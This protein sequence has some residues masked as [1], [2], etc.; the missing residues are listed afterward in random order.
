VQTV[1]TKFVPRLLTAEWKQH[2]LP[3][4]SNLLKCAETHE[5]FFKNIVTGNEIWMYNYNPKTKHEYASQGETVNLDFY[6][7]V[8][9]CFHNAVHHKP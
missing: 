5:N 9:K 1:T 6:L 2:R 4:V 7:E 8:I 3:V